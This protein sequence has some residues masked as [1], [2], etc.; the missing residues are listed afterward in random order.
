MTS[1]IAVEEGGSYIDLPDPY[2]YTT[3]SNEI[4]ESDG[5]TMDLTMVL[6]VIGIKKEIS[7]GWRVLSPEDHTRIMNLTRMTSAHKQFNVRYFDMDDKTIKFGVFY[8]GNDVA[9][10]VQIVDGPNWIN[11]NFKRYNLK[12]SM[13]EI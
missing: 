6:D 13:V 12:I 7:I 9:Q 8:R 10:S 11:D 2:E 4:I 1:I 3:K 5:R